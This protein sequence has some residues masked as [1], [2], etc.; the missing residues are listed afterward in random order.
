MPEESY[1]ANYNNSS[2]TIFYD[3]D[4]LNQQNMAC[5]S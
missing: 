2:K 5:K 3:E 4:W 1:P